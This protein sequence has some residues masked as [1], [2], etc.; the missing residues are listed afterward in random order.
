MKLTRQ[1]LRQLKDAFTEAAENSP[2]PY[3]AVMNPGNLKMSPRQL[4]YELERETPTGKYFIH[5]IEDAINHG[6]IPFGSVI[7]Q[8]TERKQLKP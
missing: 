1:Q 8:L 5:V 2:E 6:G 7:K 3:K 4:A